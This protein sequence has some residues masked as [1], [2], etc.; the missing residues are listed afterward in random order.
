MKIDMEPTVSANLRHLQNIR[1]GGGNMTLLYSEM[2]K[3]REREME[4]QKKSGRLE[5]SVQ[6]EQEEV[7][8]DKRMKWQ[9]KER[10]DEATRREENVLR[11]KTDW[12]AGRGSG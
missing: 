4:R 6:Q 3:E 5:G 2:E 7:E 12:H 10:M 8:T 9:Y 11:K 1:G